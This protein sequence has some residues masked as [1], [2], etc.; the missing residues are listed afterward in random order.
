MYYA[1]L[2]GILLLALLVSVACSAEASDDVDQDRIW[3]RYTLSYNEN[4]NNTTASARFRVGG[5]TGSAV[6]ITGPAY[7]HF[8]NESL[9]FDSVFNIHSRT[10]SGYVGSG[11]FEYGDHDNNTFVNNATISNEIDH[12]AGLTSISRDSDFEYEWQGPPLVANEEV[13]VTMTDTESPSNEVEVFSTSSTGATFV[14]MPQSVLEE[15]T[16]DNVRLVVRRWH[17]VEATQTTPEGGRLVTMY[18]P[19]DITVTLED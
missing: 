15:I 11:T 6:Q 16:N 5:P 1:R 17:N 8:N 2:A 12:P 19:E 9:P 18:R 4:T 13:V 3:A 10:L 14:M 7:I